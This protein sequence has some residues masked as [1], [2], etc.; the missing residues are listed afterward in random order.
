[1]FVK[2]DAPTQPNHKKMRNVSRTNF[3]SCKLKLI[4]DFDG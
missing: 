3:L 4:N 2:A 1:M